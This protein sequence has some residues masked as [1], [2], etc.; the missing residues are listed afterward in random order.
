M[1]RMRPR[2]YQQKF[3]KKTLQFCRC[4]RSWTPDDAI[5]VHESMNPKLI[6]HFMGSKP[7]PSDLR[8]HDFL[9]KSPKKLPSAKLTKVLP[10]SFLYI[11]SE[12]DFCRFLLESMLLESDQI[13]TR[14]KQ[15]SNVTL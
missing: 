6:G 13:V 4:A 11:Y 9:C 14:K 10:Y 7:P 12:K 15:M 3:I 8:L 5:S 1:K 2:L